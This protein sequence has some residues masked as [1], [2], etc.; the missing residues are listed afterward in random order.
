MHL[1]TTWVNDGG[2]SVMWL[3]FL[4]II[5]IVERLVGKAFHYFLQLDVWFGSVHDLTPMGNIVLHQMFVQQVGG[6]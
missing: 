1:P 4:S 2:A 3:Q 5:A 6:S